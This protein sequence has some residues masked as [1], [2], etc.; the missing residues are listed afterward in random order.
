[1]SKA[2]YCIF[3]ILFCAATAGAEPLSPSDIKTLLAR[4]R[5]KHA[6]NPN[7]Q[8]DFQEQRNVHLLE[9][10]IL[11]SGRIWVQTPNKFRRETRGNAP[12]VTMSDGQTLWIYYPNFK[13]AER[14]SLARHSPLDAVIAAINTALNLDNVENSFQTA[15]SRTAPGY[16]L[17][18]SPRTPSMRRIFDK[19][20]LRLSDDLTVETTEMLQHNGDR[21]VTTYSKQSH[22]PLNAAIFAFTP[23]PGTEVTT[24][25]GK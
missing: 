11:S 12:S 5:E 14:Y 6:N 3:L 22:T 2:L 18:L 15:G 24:P 25:L 1:M 19:L 7:L 20:I 8:A 4:I 17:V 9:E 23:P 13:S 21:V 16:E 10:P